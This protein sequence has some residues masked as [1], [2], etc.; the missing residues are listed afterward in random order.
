MVQRLSRGTHTP[1]EHGVFSHSR[2]F[3]ER[4]LCELRQLN[5][6]S[7]E[8]I[9]SATPPP[10]AF[11]SCPFHAIARI[12]GF[13]PV[14]VSTRAIPVCL[15]RFDR[16]AAIFCSVRRLLLA[17][18]CSAVQPRRHESPSASQVWTLCCASR[19]P[20]HDGCC[21]SKTK[22]L[23]LFRSPVKS[24]P[25]IAPNRKIVCSRDITQ[26]S[27]RSP[28]GRLHLR[29]SSAFLRFGPRNIRDGRI[30]MA[31]ED[32]STNNTALRSYSTQHRSSQSRLCGG[33]FAHGPSDSW[34]DTPA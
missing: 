4:L 12:D 28:R 24:F 27:R 21:A 16:A 18:R 10:R 13:C 6:I 3:F 5:G 29:S 32:R 11:A 17:A 9:S 31:N 22:T 19:R 26:W 20:H 8:T 14:R 7:V 33:A 1:R 2:P 15:R 30:A 25:P 23:L 34:R